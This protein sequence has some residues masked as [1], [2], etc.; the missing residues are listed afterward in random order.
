MNKRNQELLDSNVTKNNIFSPGYN[1][2][3]FLLNNKIFSTSCNYVSLLLVG[4]K[5]KSAVYILFLSEC[6]LTFRIKSKLM[7]LKFYI[8]F[9]GFFLYQ[10]NMTIFCFLTQ[11]SLA[12]CQTLPSFIWGKNFD[13]CYFQLL[14]LLLISHLPFLNIIIF[15][16]LKRVF[17]IL[18]QL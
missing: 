11:E 4:F 8:K 18:S 7:N 1:Y 13:N 6:F 12:F 10:Y 15:F 9:N 17:L 3:S 14:L 16:Y 2:V 5:M